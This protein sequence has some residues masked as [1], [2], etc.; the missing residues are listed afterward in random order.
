MNVDAEQIRLAKLDAERPWH[1][2]DFYEVGLIVRVRARTRGEAFGAVLR[3]R[4][5]ARDEY[6]LRRVGAAGIRQCA[7]MSL[8]RREA[9]YGFGSTTF[10]TTQRCLPILRSRMNPNFS[11]VDK[12]PWKRKPAGTE[13]ASSG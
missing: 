4:L 5:L 7:R 2:F 11:Y 9:A 13:P 1:V 8:E 3:S 12:A 6:T 10:V